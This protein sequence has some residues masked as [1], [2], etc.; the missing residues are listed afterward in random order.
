MEVLECHRLTMFG[1]VGQLHYVPFHSPVSRSQRSQPR[2]AAV[3]GPLEG[4]HV[5]RSLLQLLLPPLAGLLD[6]LLLARA[7]AALS[8]QPV[9]VEAEI[10]DECGRECQREAEARARVRQPPALVPG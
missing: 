7:Q 2:G 9:E 3:P 6:Q 5:V 8:A 1:H 10:E 4:S